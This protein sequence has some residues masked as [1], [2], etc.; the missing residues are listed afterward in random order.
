MPSPQRYTHL[1]G[2]V[3]ISVKFTPATVS[4]EA[5]SCGMLWMRQAKQHPGKAAAP[6]LKELRVLHAPYISTGLKKKR[7]YPAKS[8]NGKPW[9]HTDT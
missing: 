5:G 9:Q 1:R 2:R 8:S 7:L 3:K 6:L 4:R